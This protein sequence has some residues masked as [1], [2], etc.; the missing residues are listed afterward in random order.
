MDDRKSAAGAG[1]LQNLAE[2][3]RRV[4]VAKRL[5]CLPE[6]HVKIVVPISEPCP[7]F[8]AGGGELLVWT[9]RESSALLKKRFTV[10][11]YATTR[12][13]ARVAKARESELDLT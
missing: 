12:S 7:A 10:G 4:V 3:R 13:C 1:A 6:G 2:V 8:E 11:C 5:E 9:S